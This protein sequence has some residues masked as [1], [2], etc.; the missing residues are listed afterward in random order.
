MVN[1]SEFHKIE[2][3][4]CTQKIQQEWLTHTLKILD[5]ETFTITKSLPK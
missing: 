3:Y 1:E 5:K 4:F 2:I